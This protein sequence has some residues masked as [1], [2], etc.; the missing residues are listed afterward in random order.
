MLLLVIALIVPAL[1]ARPGFHSTG[2][3]EWRD[4][5]VGD[6]WISVKQ[7][8]INPSPIVIPGDMTVSLEGAIT[9][10]LAD[11]VSLDVLFEKSLLGRF[12]KVPCK[13]DVGTCHYTDPCHFLKVF[14]NQGTCPPQL[15]ANGLPCTCPFSPDKL[16]MPPSKF[17]VTNISDAW[18]FL[19]N[20]EY[21]V[22]ITMNDK[23]T[24]Q[25]RACMETYLTIGVK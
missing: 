20:G 7:F 1:G 25:L 11:Q 9:H 24:N 19:A 12:T 10:N 16:H 22:K 18:K 21:H 8:N 15:T 4:C 2:T 5:G 6:T 3:L 23:H 17:T 14:E 13:N